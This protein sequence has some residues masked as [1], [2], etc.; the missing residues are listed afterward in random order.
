MDRGCP[1]RPPKSTTDRFIYTIVQCPFRI[2][3]SLWFPAYL[4]HG[5]SWNASYP[6]CNVFNFAVLNTQ[7][8]TFYK[9]YKVLK[10]LFIIKLPGFHADD[11]TSSVKKDHLHRCELHLT[12]KNYYCC[13]TKLDGIFPSRLRC[14]ERNSSS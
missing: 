3:V 7:F 12:E 10:S 6:V 14:K 1:L 2:Y 9:K 5:A 4:A 13:K 11:V 8:F